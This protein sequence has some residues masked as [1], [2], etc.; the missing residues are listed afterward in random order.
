[1]MKTNRKN[2]YVWCTLLAC[3]VLFAASC[4]T[5]SDAYK[6]I[7]NMVLMNEFGLGIEAIQ[8]GQEGKKPLY[9]EKNAISLF[10]DKGLL[11][12]YAGNYANSSNDLQEAERLIGE[13]FTQSVT[14]GIASYI[15]NDN[16]KDYAG[17]DFEDIYINIFNA[18]NFHN[19]GKTDEAL[20]EI[21]KLTYSSGKLDMLAQKY[22][23]ADSSAAAD[24]MAQLASLG[25]N[26]LEIPEKKSTSFGDSALARYLSALFFLGEGNRDSARIEFERV[27]TAFA[28]N[29]EIYHQEFPKSVADAQAVPAGKARLNVV[30]FTGLSPI[31]E[32]QIIAQNF[33]FFSAEILRT[34]Q[35][36]IPVL[37]K[38]P[39]KI[40]RVEV[41]VG[42]EKFNLELLED[43]GA[44]ITETYNARFSSVF[45][46]TYLRVL[47][48]YAT[49]DIAYRIATDQGGWV[50]LGALAAAIAAKITIDATEGADIRMSRYLPD[51][52]YVGGINLDP[53]NYDVT[54]QFYSGGELVST[55]E[56]NV[57]LK[58]NAL[59]LIEG[60]NLQ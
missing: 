7:D 27:R 26:D 32:E 59:N 20:V 55:E 29:S 25:F 9:P 13:A 37:A 40:D 35:F 58:A 53:G 44:V 50:A 47:L 10:L 31:K 8:K 15:A 54:V 42:S 21:R 14:A 45:F 18:L 5:K 6:D 1:M 24:T 11:E 16:T 43:I 51:R 39:S 28:A 22:G 49:T 2:V 52:A 17:E 12:H 41:S 46:K 34:P 4:A 38:R 33:P 3:L 60:V 48:K 56:H 36:K 30:G 19:E 57:N 23:E